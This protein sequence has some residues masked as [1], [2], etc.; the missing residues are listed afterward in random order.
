MA[1]FTLYLDVITMKSLKILKY[2]INSLSE[3]QMSSHFQ[4]MK[5]KYLL[6]SI[7]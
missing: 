7:F 4:N 3:D 1:K 6:G 5:P 2:H